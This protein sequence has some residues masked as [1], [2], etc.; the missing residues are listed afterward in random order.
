MKSKIGYIQGRLVDQIDG[1]IQAFPE[2]TWRDEFPIAKRVGLG[3]IEWTLDDHQLKKNPFCTSF[4]QKEILTLSHQ[5]SIGMDS[6]TGDCFMQA[7]FWKSTGS[8]QAQLLSKLDLVI[9]SCL[10]LKVKYIVVPLVD[11]GHLENAK[12]HNELYRLL[13]DRIEMLRIS[14]VCIAFESDFPPDK[15]RDFIST[16]PADCFG[17]NYD[18]GNS[19]SLG[20]DPEKEMNA[21]APRIINVHVKDRKLGGTTVPLGSGA[22]KVKE[23]FNGLKDVQYRGN[24]I[25]QTARAVN[26][27]HEE[28]LVRNLA[29]TIEKLEAYFGP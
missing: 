11:N 15:L 28:A 21:Y 25:L 1:K 24:F 7:P 29:W 16:Y 12:Q 20:F 19:A 8:E 18:I 14:G 26:C 13:M 4:G 9:Q 22:A 2:K 6:V 5:F 27:S 23:V 10:A 17:V 3:L